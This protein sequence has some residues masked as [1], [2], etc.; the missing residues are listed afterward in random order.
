MSLAGSC[1]KSTWEEATQLLRDWPASGQ[2]TLTRACLHAQGFEE[3]WGKAGVQGAGPLKYEGG[4]AKKKVSQALL[5][6]C[7]DHRIACG[8][9]SFLTES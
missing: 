1:V 3:T 6:H 5:C 4:L 9:M 7:V 8:G 2:A